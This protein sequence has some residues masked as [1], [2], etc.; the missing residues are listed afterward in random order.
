ML[1]IARANDQIATIDPQALRIL[2]SIDSST[3]MTGVVN[4]TTDPLINEY[5]WLSPAMQTEQQPAIRIDY[6]LGTRHRLTGTFNKLWQ[7]P[8]S[9]SVEHVRP[10]VPGRAQLPSHRRPRPTRSFTLRST[11]SSQLVSE[12]RV[13]VTV[14]ERLFFGQVASTGPQTYADQGGYAID[15]DAEP[16]PDELAHG[17][18]RSRAAAPTSTRSMR[19]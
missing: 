3:R 12:L 15:L 8:Q 2:Q 18:T 9:R 13:G 17:A 19:R 1:D 5:S 10:P 16:R 4:A 14:G 7:D 11:L 6:N